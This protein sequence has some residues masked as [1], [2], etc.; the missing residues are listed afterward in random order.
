MKVN[1]PGHGVV[2]TGMIAAMILAIFTIFSAR[3]TTH[4]FVS[5]YTASR[6]L[7]SGEL[8]PRAYDDQWFGEIVQRI[9][10]SSVREIFIPNPPTMALMAVPLVGMGPQPARAIWLGVSLAAFIGGVSALTRYRARKNRDVSIPLLMLMLL[11]PAVFTNLRIGQGYLIVFALFAGATVMLLKHRDRSAGMFLGLLLALKT[12]GVALALLLIVRRRWAAISA[13]ALTALVLAIV[14]TPFI[15][16]SMWWIYPSQVRAYV[17]RPASSVTAYQTTLGM[18]R[19]LCIADPQWNPSPAA[20]CGAIAF[21]APTVIIAI[22]TLV[23]LLLARRSTSTESWIA[24]G[25]TLSVLSL[26][27]VAEP[28]FV[29][30]AIPLALLRLHTIEILVIGALLMVP[31]E[32]TAERFTAG[33]WALLAYPRLYAA[34]LLW[35]ASIRELRY[36]APTQEA[37]NNGIFTSRIRS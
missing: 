23:T 27:A 28:H 21:A 2:M 20:S 17:A 33:W 18:F 6:L 34:W 35:A 5:Y 15:D 12:S 3:S 26:P 29:L 25:T 4:G 37:G 30:M 22:A 8:G 9:T 24:A 32:Y 19:H 13:A 14:I 1:A 10:S 7:V 31:L 11:A 36:H 16:A